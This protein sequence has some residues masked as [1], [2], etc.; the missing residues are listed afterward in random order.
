MLVG[1]NNEG[2]SNILRALNI[3]FKVITKLKDGV[4]V[5]KYF[6]R[7][8]SYYLSDSDRY[9]YNWERDFPITKQSSKKFK[10]N[11]TVFNL[12]F[13]LDENERTE[14]YKCVGSYCNGDLPFI[15]KFDNKNSTE[16][17]IPKRSYAGRGNFKEK[18]EKIAEFIANHFDTIYIPA[19]RTDKLS[20][21]IIS[22]IIQKGVNLS[23]D[24]D[25]EYFEAT[26][27][28]KNKYDDI[29]KKTEEQIALNLKS[30]IPNFKDIKIDINSRQSS[31]IF[32]NPQIHINDGVNTRLEYKGDGLKSLVALGIM[33]SLKTGSITVA[34]EEPESHLHPD[35]IRKVKS[36]IENIAK[37]QQVI[38][39]THSAI[40]VNRDNLKSNIIIAKNHAEICDNIKK[41]RNELGVIVSDNLTNATH[42]I[43]VEGVSDQKS[44]TAIFR[45][46]SKIIKEAIKNGKLIINSIAGTRNL[47][48]NVSKLLSDFCKVMVL[49]DDDQAGREAI[50]NVKSKKLLDEKYLFSTVVTG[51]IESEFEDYINPDIYKDYLKEQYGVKIDSAFSKGKGKWS[52]KINKL[53]ETSMK[54]LPNDKLEDIKIQISK[55]IENSTEE[56]VKHNMKNTVDHFI[57]FIEGEFLNNIELK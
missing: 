32:I 18:K 14:F 40:M 6:Q 35:A 29:A 27:K 51:N 39:T 8:S 28:I 19:I 9:L 57:N 31:R 30:F 1:K 23:L 42:V 48:Y 46:K 15:I 36:V 52:T 3:A 21:D 20:I 47:Y 2:K 7:N 26:N 54:V 38:I 37:N 5:S 50:R 24:E 17:D 4:D 25:P 12:T 41:I 22:D 43:L 34:I 11:K 49:V 10:N 56:I 45:K 13:L 16:V 53:F 33:N 55:L 44:L